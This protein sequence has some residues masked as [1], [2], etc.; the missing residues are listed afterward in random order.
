[1]H[2]KI[3]IEV[4]N[5]LSG[6]DKWIKYTWACDS[7]GEPCAPAGKKAVRW[8]LD[9]AVF[10]AAYDL[11]KSPDEAAACLDLLSSHCDRKVLNWHDMHSRKFRHVTKLL[12]VAL[13]CQK[14][15]S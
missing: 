1:M 4:K 8:S 9:G 3:L 15:L 13:A 2:T 5:I 10:K 11:G 6:E 12:E 14:E 7:D